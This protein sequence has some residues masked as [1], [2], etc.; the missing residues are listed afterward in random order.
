MLPAIPL[1]TCLMKYSHN[2]GRSKSNQ[3]IS[4]N[5]L[6][7]ILAS[8]FGTAITNVVRLINLKKIIVAISIE[9]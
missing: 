8:N 4:A 6:V 2:K 1:N 9:Q 5:S 7:D 3:M